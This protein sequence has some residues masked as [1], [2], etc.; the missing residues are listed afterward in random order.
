MLAA[1]LGNYGIGE[2]SGKGGEMRFRAAFLNRI[3]G[4]FPS[5][6]AEFFFIL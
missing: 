1:H 2:F 3:K 6:G 4:R 5:G